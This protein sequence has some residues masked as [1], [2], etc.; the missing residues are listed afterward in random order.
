MKRQELI[1][2]MNEFLKPTREK[3]KSYVENR[4]EVDKILKDATSKAKEKASSTI[5]DVKKA[6]MID[7]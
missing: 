4:D 1:E 3:R 6:M 2:K 5:K 7:Y